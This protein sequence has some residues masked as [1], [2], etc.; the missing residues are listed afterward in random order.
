MREEAFLKLRKSEKYSN[1]R[2]PASPRLQLENYRIIPSI[3]LPNRKGKNPVI[4]KLHLYKSA[5]PIY[6][7]IDDI[8]GTK[9]DQFLINGLFL[10]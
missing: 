2:A 8:T 4:I 3:W 1:I 10:I 7:D 9:N 6:L 5:C